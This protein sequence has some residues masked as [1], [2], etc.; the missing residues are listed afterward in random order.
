MAIVPELAGR[1]RARWVMLA[2]YLI[3]P[4]ARDGRRA[5]HG[6]RGSMTRVWERYEPLL[7]YVERGAGTSDRR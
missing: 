6:I 2:A 3:A 5:R 4:W 7:Q 1:R